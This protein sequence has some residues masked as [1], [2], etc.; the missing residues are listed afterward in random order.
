[1]TDYDS[2]EREQGLIVEH[3]WRLVSVPITAM[4]FMLT[5]LAATSILEMANREADRVASRIASIATVPSPTDLLLI[6][7]HDVWRDEEYEVA[8]IEPAGSA[9][10]VLPPGMVR[11]PKPGEAVV[12]PAL[13]RLASRNPDLAARYPNRSVLGVEGLRSGEEL[14]AYVRVGE[15]RSLA[16]SRSVARAGE[17]GTSYGDAR[18]SGSGSFVPP[19]PGSIA[20]PIIVGVLG[21]LVLPGSV[22]LVVGLTTASNLRSRS[23][24]RWRWA[25]ASV[26]RAIVPRVLEVSL[27][28]LPGL[29]LATISWGL[30]S[31]RLERVP[32][33]ARGVVRGDLR[34]PWWL[35]ATELVAGAALIAVLTAAMTTMT[36]M[37]RRHP[38][39]RIW[40]R[41][42]EATITLQEIPM[43][44]AIVALALGYVMVGPEPVLVFV[45]AL[46]VSVPL[47]LPGVFRAVGTKLAR[48]DSRSISIVGQKVEHNP[49]QAIQPFI[50][51]TAWVI[52]AMVSTGFVALALHM[53]QPLPTST[54]RAQAVFVNWADPHP[55]DADRL[56]DALGR[57][58]VVK[59]REV[60]RTRDEDTLIVGS[61]CQQLT[62]Y[63]PGSRCRA[64]SP[65]ELSAAT[66]Q[67]LTDV[68]APATGGADTELRVVPSDEVGI[69]ANLA[70]IDNATLEPL[71]DRVRTAAMQMLPAPNIYSQLTYILRATPA[72]DWIVSGSVAFFIFL[73]IGQFF[74]MVGRFLIMRERDA[75][76]SSVVFNWSPSLE[77]RL[78]AVSYGTAVAVAFVTGLV[79][80]TVLVGSLGSPV[81]WQSVGIVLIGTI[82]VGLL[83]ALSIWTLGS[84]KRS[85]GHVDKSLK[86]PPPA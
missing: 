47:A 62:A 4:M 71:E 50:G 26:R 36:R 31:P 9:R 85:N 46:I 70:V 17:F 35:L 12:S 48:F 77:V 45:I 51:I 13:E 24:S 33:V 86:M 72:L 75:P 3:R 79:G 6:Y 60:A 44:F 56:A 30:V 83:G 25:E 41:F 49:F 23:S 14:F 15:D 81:P 19:V 28:A 38:A 10:P 11:L 73:T 21:F 8:W 27:L 20:P 84:G 2:R 29:V 67:A 34:I 40:T 80:C 32:L 65:F 69:S 52:L 42:R 7:G 53:E 1:M 76:N 39:A 68:L 82:A 55:N 16:E 18:F 5:V 43:G 22:V 63:L 78:F 66:S 61:N 59:F 37:R 54:K 58:L 64:G 74:S 57:G